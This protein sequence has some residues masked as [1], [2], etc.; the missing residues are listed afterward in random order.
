MIRNDLRNIAI[1]A[2]VDH[3][4]TTLVDALLR[5]GGMFREN[6]VVETCVMD[7]NPLERERGITILAKN[8]SCIYKDIKI[9]IVDTPGHADFS[10]EVERVLKLINGVVLLVDAYEGPMPQTRFVLQKA[11]EMGHKVIICINK[12][13]K[14]DARPAEV[15]EEVYELLLDL[16][17]DDEQLESPIVYCS[18]RTG[19]ASYN[20]DSPG[21]SLEPLFETIL[22]HIPPPEGDEEGP[23]Q[24]LV[25]AIDYNDY[26]GRIAIGRIERG[27]MKANQ[28]VVVCNYFSPEVFNSK[29]TNIYQFNGLNRI[30]V[31]TAMVGDVVCFSGIENVTIGQTICSPLKV[32][33]LNFVKI[34]EPTLQM[35]FS[36]NDS[37]FAGREGKFVTSRHLRARLYK[38]L[39]KDVSLKVEDG[40]A[41]DSFVVSGRG[42]I[43]LSILIENMR[44][45]GYEFQVSMPRVINKIIDG[46]LYEPMERLTVEVPD[47]AVSSIMES[48]GIR[49]GELINMQPYNNR[50][51]MEFKVPERGLLGYRNEFMTDT[52]GEG[53][54]SSLFDGY[55]PAKKSI[56]RRAYG[57]LVAYESGEAVTYGLYNAQERG[58][59]FI[60]PQ[61]PVYAGMVVGYSPKSEDIVVNVCKRK[62]VT[63][64]RAAGSDEAL[65]LETPRKFSLE[66]CIEFIAEDEMLEV[67]PKNL[68]IRKII[69]SHEERMRKIMK[70]RKNG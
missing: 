54:M 67:T 52:H 48:M 3:G 21:D 59:L 53:V 20:P 68:R 61:T 57:A 29:I 12:C 37:P 43:H 15:L 9:N 24:V 35:V 69:L 14:P 5:Q 25:S 1:I 31:E 28:D 17:A 26:V 2:H 50:V 34:S 40:D 10:G 13:D 60:G 18:G 42:E 63:N 11:L 19:R 64:M 66:E 33:P 49:Q 6:Q 58:V 44:R 70:E 46:K 39:L 8:T 62:H 7:N 41:T 55:A 32:E 36:V 45:E 30:N 4:K 23:L 47:W 27:V 65:R 56:P 51:K 38:E 16:N 22:K